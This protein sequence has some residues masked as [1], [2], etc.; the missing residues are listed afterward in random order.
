[1]RPLRLELEGFTSFR[2]RAEIDFA[3]ADYFALVGPTGAGKS[4]I[5]DAMTFALYGCVPRYGD[6]RLVAPTISQGLLEAKLRLDFSVA[7]EEYT[8]VR[9]VRRRGAGATTKEARLEHGGE[10]LAGDGD[11]VTAAVERLLGL[12][13]DHFTKC[14]VLPQG[15]FARFLHDARKDRNELLKKLLDFGLYDAISDLARARFQQADARVALLEDQLVSGA[16]LRSDDALLA[17]S[18]RVR[19]LAALIVR[20][21]EQQET[22]DRLKSDAEAAERARDTAVAQ[23]RSLRALA[24]PADVASLANRLAEQAAMAEQLEAEVDK[25]TAELQAASAAVAALPDAAPLHTAQAAHRDHRRV[26][27]AMG[28][29]APQRGQAERDETTHAS[30]AAAASAS[31][32][33]ARAALQHVRVEHAAADLARVLAAGEPCPVCQQTVHEVP[34]VA[35]PADLA[36]AEAAVHTAEE[37]ARTA[38]AAAR[39]AAVARARIE[40]QYRGFEAQLAELAPRI[41]AFPDATVVD[42]ELERIKRVVDAEQQ[43]RVTETTARQR[44]ADARKAIETT[45]D[46]EKGA[47][48]TL[49][50]ARDDVAA[51]NPPPIDRTDLAR[52]WDVLTSWA[53]DM[54]DGVDALAQG[55]DEVARQ[56][57][58]E[59]EAVVAVLV[60]ACRAAGVDVGEG[61]KAR[62]I[63]VREHSKAETAVEAIEKARAQSADQERER[64]AVQKAGAVAREL[65][66]HLGARY[67]EEWLIDEAIAALVARATELLLELSTQQYSLTVDDQGNF[68]VI[69][70]RNADERRLAKTLSGGETFLAS[71]ALALALADQIGS[72]ASEG[73][74]RLESI[75]LDEG[76][77]TL[78]PET[79]D[80]VAAAIENLAASGRAV[81]II[82]HVRELAER[83]PVRFEVTKGPGG[84]S[85][86][87]V[88]A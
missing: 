51:L 64:A 44:L 23:S 52:A 8:V 73:A 3:G 62:D 86:R 54:A 48:L 15:D 81:G 4:S 32:D 77:G 18:E 26:T 47:W 7:N 84:S 66:K 6:N 28:E 17:A 67:F 25:A 20:I 58:A 30:A 46:R 45:R 57:R 53:A 79:L 37:A 38:T 12:R 63:A 35:V 78:D 24:T 9:V 42:E 19:Q 21:D 68:A 36:T 85:V 2:E 43:A 80:T 74:A 69:D 75:F 83:V 1:V 88:A 82:T 55:H 61:G 40:E 16:D 50:R 70:H 14:V 34:S 11:S 33:A 72:L 76:F 29:L 22:L 59:R 65:H 5:V 10:V 56:R 49:E 39:E 13:F 87:Q 41:A 31:L 71:L 60:D 27:A